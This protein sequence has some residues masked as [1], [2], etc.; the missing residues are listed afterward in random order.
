MT[1]LFYAGGFVF[2]EYE[3]NEIGENVHATFANCS[4]NFHP[5]GPV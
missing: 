2:E 1:G 3:T 4:S 5:K